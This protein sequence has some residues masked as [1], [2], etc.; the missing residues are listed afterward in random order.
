MTKSSLDNLE[1]FYAR[2]RHEWHQ[3]LS[4]NH[5]TSPGVWLIYYKKNN[6][7]K[8]VEY[9]DAVQEAL[10]FGW[11]DSK[12]NALDEERYMQVFTP[13]K[14]GSTWSKLN[15]NRIERLIEK[16]L[17]KPAGLKKVNA[18]KKDGSWTFLDDIEDLI[19]PEDLKKTLNKNITAIENFNSFNDSH[20]KQI[21]Y[22]VASAKMR[23]TRKRRIKMI[24]EA[25][26]ENK[27]PFN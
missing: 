8:S 25:A 12:V 18:A 4:E 24:F 9:E 19:V 26:L 6:T 16:K 10:I 23:K 15:K 20:K 7:Q 3:W 13:R 27:M 5:N 22:W 2:N 1:R 21:L 17:M 14:Q 11:I